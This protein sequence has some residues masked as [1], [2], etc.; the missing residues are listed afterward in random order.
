MISFEL[1]M[2]MSSFEHF[3]YFEGK[4]SHESNDRSKKQNTLEFKHY[5]TKFLVQLTFQNM[6][7]VLILIKMIQDRSSVL[8]GS[9]M[10]ELGTFLPASSGDT[11]RISITLQRYKDKSTMCYTGERSWS[12]MGMVM[13]DC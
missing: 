6:D 10:E 7:S 13:K 1:S 2:T 3:E 11:G 8:G 4:V 12:G 9:C 5:V